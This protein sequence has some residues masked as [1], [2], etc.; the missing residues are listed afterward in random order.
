MAAL[1]EVVG[2]RYVLAGA[3]SLAA[4]SYDATG[5]K[6]RPHAVVLP[7]SAQE[8]A[9]VVQVAEAFGL[10]VVPRGAGTS[11]SGGAVPVHGGVV[12]ATSRLN[13]IV[14]FDA[15]NRIVVV[16]PG[17]TN[18]RLQEFL[19]PHGFFF[20]ADPSSY[21]VSTIGGNVAENAGG[22]HCL[23]YGVTTHHVLG[24]KVVL[25]GGR[26]V[27]LG[28]PAEDWPGYDLGGV[29]T[30]SEGTMGVVTEITLRV[31]P[32]SQSR[33]TFLVAF[34]SVDDAASAVS[35]MIAAKLLP[36]AIELMDQPSIRLVNAAVGA[37]YP[38][39]A[40]A[41]LVVDLEGLAGEVLAQ[42]QIMR[43][44][45]QRHG[46]VSV[47]EADDT[48]RQEALWR[49]RRAHYGAMARA[50]R[51]GHVWIQDVTVP[52]QHLPE[53]F[54]RVLEIGQ[55][56]GLHI[57]CAAHA[58][59]GN[60]HP[61]IPFD[62]HDEDEL[63]RLYQADQEI[64]AACLALGG[65]ITG[66]HGVGFEKIENMK[67]MYG[68]SE[69]ALMREVRHVFDPHERFNPGKAVPGPADGKRGV[70]LFGGDRT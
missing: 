32:L 49:G 19:R 55:R 53:M 30:G 9:G 45:C 70:W 60:L 50:T 10:P 34:P 17:V 68:P 51:T 4:Y 5:L 62:P 66:E 48:A 42:A 6:R 31:L 25:A 46:A 11:L 59:D 39:E 21:R 40:G 7:G 67:L 58:G 20:A 36:G 15:Q 61:S 33:R 22:P 37:G 2:A 23:R 24:L 26:L 52:R 14:S 43:E 18:L 29:L 35:D 3:A 12:V 47:D 38:E 57:D 8:V 27:E 63:S 41:V 13:R 28:G 44:I 56:Y 65:S 54:R 69:L 1:A 16:E 64:M